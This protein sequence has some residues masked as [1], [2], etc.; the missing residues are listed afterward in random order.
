[1]GHSFLTAVIPQ[2]GLAVGSGYSHLNRVF[3]AVV[4]KGN[5]LVGSLDAVN[6]HAHSA[7]PGVRLPDVDMVD[8]L[9]IPVV[10]LERLPIRWK[11]RG[12]TQLVHFQSQ[13]QE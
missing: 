13:P 1:M 6:G 5:R 11:A 10:H 4:N 8:R 7:I 9:P 2:T 12:K 3:L